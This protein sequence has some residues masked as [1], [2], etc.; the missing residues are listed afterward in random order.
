M[1]ASGLWIRENTSPVVAEVGPP[2]ATDECGFT[3]EKLAV[4]TT[5]FLEDGTFL[6][7]KRPFPSAIGQTGILTIFIHDFFG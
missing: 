7:P 2:F 3:F 5:V 1:N 6:F 4:C